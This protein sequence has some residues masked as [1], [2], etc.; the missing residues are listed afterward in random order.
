MTDSERQSLPVSWSRDDRFLLYLDRDPRGDRYMQ[1][2]A[3]TVEP[4]HNPIVVAAKSPNDILN[5]Q[6]S[7]DGRWVTYSRDE[8]GREEVFVTSFPDGQEK[9]QISSAGGSNPRW[10]REGR[11]LLFSAFDGTIMS[12]DVDE[13]RAFKASAPR[14][15]FSLPEGTLN[16]EAA[17][18][19][20]R[21]LELRRERGHR[22]L[23]GRRVDISKRFHSILLMSRARP[24]L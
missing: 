18:D 6:F 13:S 20:Q 23:L 12:V 9:V 11:E 21:F 22:V 3:I 10:T 4:P 2:S 24:A 19:G 14:A 1:L 17:P 16:W 5:A 15:L 8:S 7:P